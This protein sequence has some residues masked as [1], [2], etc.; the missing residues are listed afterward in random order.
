MKILTNVEVLETEK[1]PAR[2]SIE[3]TFATPIFTLLKGEIIVKGKKM[4]TK[5][6]PMI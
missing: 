6:I 3:L 4:N 1:E 2:L 5:N